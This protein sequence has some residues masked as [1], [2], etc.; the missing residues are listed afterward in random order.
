MALVL[1]P[2]LLVLLST[3]VPPC[4]AF[5]QERPVTIRKIRRGVTTQSRSSTVSPVQAPGATPGDSAVAGNRWVH[6]LSGPVPV[7][8]RLSPDSPILGMARRGTRHPLVREGESWCRIRFEDKIGWIERRHTEVVGDTSSSSI[9]LRE[10]LIALIVVAATAL[11]ILIMRAIPARRNRVKGEWFAAAGGPKK[12]LLVSHGE[13]L[14]PRY[15]TNRTSTLGKCFTEIGF[16]LKSVENINNVPALL[17]HYLP[18]VMAVDWRLAPGVH[19]AVET[20]LS[21]RPTTSNILVVFYNVPDPSAVQSSHVIPHAQYL[22]LSFT[23]RDL[24]SLITPIIITGSKP[25]RIRQ[26]VEETALEGNVTTESLFEVFQF[27]EIGKKTG[28]LLVEST[29]PAGMVYFNDGVIVYAASRT[30]LGKE[31]LFE[32]L[33]INHGKFKFVV[34]KEP[35]TPNCTIPALGILMEWTK[36]V[37]EAHG[38]RL[39]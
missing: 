13:T 9:V 36:A 27:V 29:R 22:G 1:I 12:A 7:L 38:D 34:G 31:A 2:F 16:E 11:L 14:V 20:T 25:R 37:D 32:I 3:I 5:S 24:F 18:D 30:T 10:F 35:R 19:A 21:S 8:Q 39:R 17:L 26:S 33:K 28:C 23:D 4:V 15:L 6:V